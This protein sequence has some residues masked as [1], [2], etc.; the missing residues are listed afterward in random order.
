MSGG[1]NPLIDTGKLL[2]PLAVEARIR[3]WREC[4]RIL[5]T[6]RSALLT[7]CSILG[8]ISAGYPLRRDPVSS[9]EWAPGYTRPLPPGTDRLLFAEELPSRR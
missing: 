5:L 9:Y 2:M 7:R 6:L 3:R 8:V 1:D 4:R